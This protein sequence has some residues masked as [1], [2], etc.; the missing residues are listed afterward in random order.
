MGAVPVPGGDGSGSGVWEAGD[1]VDFGGDVGV[2]FAELHEGLEHFGVPAPGELGVGNWFQPVA[3][4]DV[5]LEAGLEEVVSEEFRAVDAA[6]SMMEVC[7][8]E[9]VLGGKQAQDDPCLTMKGSGIGNR[10]EDPTARSEP[11]TGAS[12]DC[13]RVS[14]MLKDVA[15]DDVVEG[16]AG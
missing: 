9:R 10:S 3:A 12:Q 6:V 1:E 2:T 14:D 13:D 8:V 4:E 11:S 15:E 5:D 16:S 7:F